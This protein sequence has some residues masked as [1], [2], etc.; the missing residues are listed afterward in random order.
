MFRF[1][2]ITDVV[3]EPNMESLDQESHFEY[4]KPQ[5][6]AIAHLLISCKGKKGF[7]S[8]IMSN[9]NTSCVNLVKCHFTNQ[10]F[11]HSLTVFLVSE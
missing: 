11:L 8:A 6:F 3:L 2:V 10:E 9:F 4:Q 5:Y 1:L 7:F